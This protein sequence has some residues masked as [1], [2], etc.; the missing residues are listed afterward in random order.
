MATHSSVLAW[1]IPGTGEPGG[2]PSMGLHSWTWL[3]RLSSSSFKWWDWMPWSLFFE[4]WV[5][6]QLFHSPLSLSSRDSYRSPLLSTIR[7][8]SSAYM[9]LLMFLP[10]I[11]I[12]AYA[13]SSRAFHWWYIFLWNSNF[14]SFL[15]FFLP[16]PYRSIKSR[17]IGSTQNETTLLLHLKPLLSLDLM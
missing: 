3:K 4:C 15:S 11:L 7:V 14:G 9:R 8:V 5:L 6:S 17:V 2:L 1:R 16:C 13:S 10:A 12:P